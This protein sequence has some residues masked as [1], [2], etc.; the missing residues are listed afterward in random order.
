MKTHLPLPEAQRIADAFLT[1]IR[2]FCERAEAAGSV[3][4]GKAEVG[5]IELVVQPILTPIVG[6][7]GEQ[8]GVQDALAGFQWSAWGRVVK[9]GDRYKQILMPQGVAL[10]VFIVRP[11]VQWGLMFLMRTGPKAFS[12]WIVTPRSKGGALPS[13]LRVKGGAIWRDGEIL[14]TPT[15]A[16]V[17]RLLGLDYIPPA[18]RAP[19]W[20]TVRSAQ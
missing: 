5:D 4:R 13:H 15:E 17:F 6:L 12:Q 8:V 18:K 2:P 16:D 20:R 11:P 3:R 10:D 7:F 14:P 19:R 9:N 1:A